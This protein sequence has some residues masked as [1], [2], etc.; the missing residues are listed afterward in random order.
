MTL[1]PTV[2]IRF[3]YGYLCCD[4][5]QIKLALNDIVIQIEFIDSELCGARTNLL[6]VNVS[7]RDRVR[8]NEKTL[9]E[10]DK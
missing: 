4:K 10:M 1:P 6:H 7:Y 5:K 3:S 8:L 2:I 9:S